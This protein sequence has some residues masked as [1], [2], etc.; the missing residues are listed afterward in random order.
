MWEITMQ[1]VCVFC[2]SKTGDRPGYSAVARRLGVIAGPRGLDLVSGAG[3]V[4][5]M[6]VLADAALQAGGRVIGVIPQALV[7]R[8]L[9]HEGL[10]EMH[11]VSSMHERKAK[12]AD[13][14]EAFIA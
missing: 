2:G 11:I 7:E 5:L 3:H 4:G 12:M 14:S 6:G 9:A 13:F 8:E 1:R 10:S